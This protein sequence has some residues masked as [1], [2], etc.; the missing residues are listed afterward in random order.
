MRLRRIAVDSNRGG[1]QAEAQRNPTGQGGGFHTWHRLKLGQ[2]LAVELQSLVTCIARWQKAVRAEQNVIRVE[3]VIK[4]LR[5]A[6]AANE[7]PGANQQQQLQSDLRYC[8]AAGES[9]LM[10]SSGRARALVLKHCL[11]RE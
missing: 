6:E 8:Q 2:H 3:T 4:S 10:Q 1:A 5:V 7:E 9:C 11:R